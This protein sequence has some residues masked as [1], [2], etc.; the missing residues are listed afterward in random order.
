MDVGLLALGAAVLVV[1]LGGIVTVVVGPQGATFQQKGIATDAEITNLRTGWVKGWISSSKAY[2]VDYTYFAAP[3]GSEK[4]WQGSYHQISEWTYN[5]LQVGGTIQIRYLP[6][7]PN[8]SLPDAK[9][10][11]PEIERKNRLSCFTYSI[12]MAV[13]FGC[14]GVFF[15]AQG[16][17]KA[18]AVNQV[19]VV[20]NADL[21]EI[22]T[23][24]DSQLSGWQSSATTH[25]VRLSAADAGFS[26]STQMREVYYGTCQSK[27]AAH[28]YLYV[29]NTIYTGQTPSPSWLGRAY[30][31]TP[32]TTDVADC[33][34]EGWSVVSDKIVKGD[35]HDVLFNYPAQIPFYQLTATAQAK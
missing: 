3:P 1:V 32:G 26:P 35:W 9:Y 10:L 16:P 6:D 31:Y 4:V 34:P 15:L 27:G 29:M 25:Q 14:V 19:A 33:L 20:Q 2:F 17:S 12:S 8:V 22:H 11:D 23:A 13:G 7:R 5:H 21:T 24:L 28:F 18:P 30:T